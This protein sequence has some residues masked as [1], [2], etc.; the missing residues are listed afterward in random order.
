MKDLPADEAADEQDAS[1]DV[2]MESLRLHAATPHHAAKI[3]DHVLREFVRPYHESMSWG[4]RLLTLD[5]SAAFR[6]SDAFR[7]ALRHADSSTGSN[8]YESPDGIA[9]RYNTLIWAARACL[10]LPGDYV[11]CGVYRGDMTWMIARTV[12]L[13]SS[14]KTLYLYDT[15]AGCAQRICHPL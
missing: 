9:W 2:V 11:E 1:L 8:Q 6:D 14:G 13:A 15:F 4:D 10:S 3:V 12:D 5:K 7:T